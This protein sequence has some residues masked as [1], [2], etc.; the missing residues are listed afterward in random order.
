[1]QKTTDYF[2]NRKRSLRPYLRS[3]PKSLH[4]VI[5]TAVFPR[6]EDGSLASPVG[7]AAEGDSKFHG[8]A[9]PDGVP[10]RET[11]HDKNT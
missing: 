9:G 6:K 8:V 5:L 11:S 3:L 7:L 1:M 4:E 2:V 10:L